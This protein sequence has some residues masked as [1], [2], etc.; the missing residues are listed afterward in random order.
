[1]KIWLDDKRPMPE[2]FDTHVMSAFEAIDLIKTGKV[3]KI[4][5]DN[6]LGDRLIVGEGWMVADFIEECAYYNGIP[7][8]QCSVHSANGVAVQRMKLTLERAN[9]YWKAHEQAI[10]SSTAN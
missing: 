1:M 9:I 4:S 10:K 3:T 8:I 7:K 6:D 5:L 2:G